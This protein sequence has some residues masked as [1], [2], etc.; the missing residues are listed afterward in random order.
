MCLRKLFPWL[1]TE[2]V[3]EPIPDPIPDPVPGRKRIALLF[4]INDYSGSA[5]DLRGCI[6]DIEDV[7]KKL[8][9]EFSDFIITLYKDSQVTC[10][11]FYNTIKSAILAAKAGDVIY[12]HY[13]GHGTQVPSASEKNGYH[14]ALYLYDGPFIDDLVQ[15]LQALI[16]FGVKV[17]FKL[18]SCFSGDF[19]RERKM[20]LIY[21]HKRFHHLP[22]V[23][24]MHKA[25][26]KFKRYTIKNC[27]VFSGCD[28]EQTSADAYFNGRYNGA[29]TYYDN[30][31]Y[32]KSSSYQEEI[33]ELHRHLPNLEE[34]YDQSP[35]LDGD[36]LLF[37]EK[38][39]N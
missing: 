25:V 18:D 13:S 38:V 34:D 2:P 36:A 26:T 9:A 7:A 23:P 11:V 16:P 3:P 4:G 22:G 15:E 20:N 39:F 14:E 31:S 37:N 27:L 12:V 19:L 24:I 35:T 28:E 21:N 33:T 32:N 5:N 29:F 10:D 1:Y 30:M 17:I 6:N 8:R